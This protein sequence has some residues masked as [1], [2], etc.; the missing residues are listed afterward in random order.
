MAGSVN[1]KP[2]NF[3]IQSNEVNTCHYYISVFLT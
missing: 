1:N 2:K 3:W